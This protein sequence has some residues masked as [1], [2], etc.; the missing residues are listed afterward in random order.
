MFPLL[1]GRMSQENIATG[2]RFLIKEGADICRF[3]KWSTIILLYGKGC[4]CLIRKRFF[5]RFVL[6]AMIVI[7][8][9][10]VLCCLMKRGLKRI[11]LI[12]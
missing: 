4:K 9:L 7:S 12:W 3:L 8:L 11:M 6:K 10:L 2:L 1:C 5:S